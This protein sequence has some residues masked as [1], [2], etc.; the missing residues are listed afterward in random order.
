MLKTWLNYDSYTNTPTLD[1]LA[2]SNYTELAL[3]EMGERDVFPH[4]GRDSRIQ[5][6]GANGAVYPIVTGTFGGVDFLHSVVGEG[7][8]RT[9]CPAILQAEPS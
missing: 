9:H 2:H 1:F 6:E 5:L 3:I 4:V 7:S 8:C